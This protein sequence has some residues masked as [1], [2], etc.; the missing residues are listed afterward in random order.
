M[1][2]K[3]QCLLLLFMGSLTI[4]FAQTNVQLNIHHKLGSEDFGMGAVATNNLGN[5][6]D[7]TRLE[8]Y[9]AEIS[10]IHDGG[11]ETP[12]T[13][14]YILADATEETSVELGD[15]DV[16][17][18]EAIR[19]HVGVDE[20]NNHADPTLWHSSH[21]LSPQW[22]SMHWGWTSGYRF[23]A[24]EGNSGANMSEIWQ[25]HALEDEN[26]FQTEIPVVLTA[27]NDQMII[28]LDA[29]YNRALENIDLDD[30][31]IVHGG[32]GEA[33]ETL[34]NFQDYV[35]TQS[36]IVSS[37]NEL[38]A[39]HQLRVFPNPAVSGAVPQFIMETAAVGKTYEA[40][41]TNVQGQLVRSF[42]GLVSQEVVQVP[43][44][45]A[46]IYFIQVYEAGTLIAS[47]KMVVQ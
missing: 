44:L 45:E 18:L 20:A 41:V 10:L 9:I 37:T 11:Q 26:Y 13:D 3:V 36:N 15:F 22:P 40:Q 16:T 2:K 34:R 46:G 12:V 17:S 47:Q 33:K 43:N 31:P 19:F 14:L 1:T 4:S 38:S 35:F 6:F 28:N 24:F 23:V 5:T 25:I 32:Y 8:Y 29:D 30:G 39:S 7:F 27:S 42:T 21:P